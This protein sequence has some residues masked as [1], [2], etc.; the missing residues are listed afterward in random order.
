MYVAESFRPQNIMD[1]IYKSNSF[2]GP[3]SVIKFCEAHLRGGGGGRG[4]WF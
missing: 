4:S 2:A 1:Y 3:Q